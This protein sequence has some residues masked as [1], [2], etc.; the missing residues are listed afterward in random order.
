MA[1]KTNL[2]FRNSREGHEFY[3]CRKSHQI[4]AALATE[5]FALARVTFSDGWPI[6]AAFWLEWGNS[7]AGRILLRFAEQQMNML[8][9][10]YI[11]INA[12]SCAEIIAQPPNLR[13][14]ALERCPYP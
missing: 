2:E 3:S 12:E 4:T 10:D 5:G 11:H 14:P 8:R 13:M 7:K 1:F 6:Q 9:H